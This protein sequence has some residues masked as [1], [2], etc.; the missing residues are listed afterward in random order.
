MKKV[1]GL[2]KDGCLKNF[3]TLHESISN[4]DIFDILYF[5]YKCNSRIVVLVGLGRMA[6]FI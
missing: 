6:I 2:S 4:S 5:V 1:R 3:Y